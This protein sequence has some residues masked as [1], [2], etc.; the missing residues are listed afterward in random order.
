MKGVSLSTHLR[1]AFYMKR[2]IPPTS[3]SFQLTQCWYAHTCRTN[4]YH[5]RFRDSGTQL[6]SGHW[7]INRL[8]FFCQGIGCYLVE[9]EL[10]KVLQL[11]YPTISYTNK[12]D[13]WSKK[14]LLTQTLHCRTLKLLR[15]IKTFLLAAA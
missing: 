3:C 13:E 15:K 10:I 6:H 7:Q 14:T 12:L 8:H 11:K 5:D 9:T 2:W 1:L 4:A